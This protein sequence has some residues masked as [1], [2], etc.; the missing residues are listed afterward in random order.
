MKLNFVFIVLFIFLT[1]WACTNPF[2]TR[3]P[4]VP[5]PTSS[6]QALNNLQNDPDSLLAKIRYAFNLKNSSFYIEC[7]ADSNQTGK[8]FVFVPEK[9]ESYRLSNWGRQDELNYFNN[10][11]NNR[12]VQEIGIE[13]IDV[14]PWNS[15]QNSTDTLQTQFSYSIRLKFRTRSEVYQGR[16]FIRLLRSNFSQW[17]VFYW[18]D[19]KMSSQSP[20]STWTTIKANYRYN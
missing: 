3:T 11:I 5:A 1:I 13:F 12:D 20:D 2:S 18:E 9:D 6:T 19:F 4:T 7:L 10:L 14:L 16:T 17:Y 15:S 8:G